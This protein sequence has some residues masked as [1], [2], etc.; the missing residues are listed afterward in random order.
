MIKEL[1]N[2]CLYFS[3]N[4]LNRLMT[5]LADE[6]FKPLGL[7][8]TYAYLLLVLNEIDDVTSKKLSEELFLTQSTVTRLVDKLVGQGYVERR[9]VGRNSFVKL[10]Q[11]GKDIQKD[12]RK[13]WY[14]LHDKY[15]E[16]IGKEKAEEVVR[17]LNLISRNLEEKK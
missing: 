12:L 1:N 13:H 15:E 7:S 6:T 10:T 9:L 8:P 16:I 4:R 11:K 2:S 17:E 5:K 14:I 3:S